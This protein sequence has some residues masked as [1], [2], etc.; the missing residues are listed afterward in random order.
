MKT[1]LSLVIPCLNEVE[2]IKLFLERAR[3]LF[4]VS[5]IELII[6]DNGSTDDTPKL[7]DEILV[8]YPFARSVRL[9]INKGYGYGILQGL[10]EANGSLVG[11]THADM[12]TDPLDVLDAYKLF[13]ENQDKLY[14]KGLRGKRSYFD[15]L[16]TIGMAIFETLVFKT[17]LWDINAQPTIFN[18]ELLD[19]FDDPPNDFSLDLYSYCLAKMENYKI[20]RFPVAFNKRVHGSSTWNINLASKLRFVKNTLIYSLILRGKFNS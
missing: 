6:V 14:V 10:K 17:F 5:N 9:E 8:N 3:N 15:S 1:R 11:W 4:S 2:N 7:L 16:F 20:S 12:Q 19:F 13:E 18:R